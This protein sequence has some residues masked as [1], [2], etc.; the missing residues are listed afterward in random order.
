[1]VFHTRRRPDVIGR[2][3]VLIF[4]RMQSVASAEILSIG[5][6]LLLGDIVDT[7]SAWLA[8]EL[9]ARSIDVYW[10]QRVGDNRLRIR[11]ALEQALGRS[12]LVL[13]SGGLGPTDDDMTRESIADTLGETP[14]IDDTLAAGLRERFASFGRAMPEKNLKQAWRI[15]SAEILPNPLG[16]APGW[17]V[18]ARVGGTTGLI[19]TLPGP[20]RELK[21]MF[22]L[23]V[24][25]RLDLPTSTLHV[26][27]F[28]TFGVGESAVAERLGAWTES[29]NP[30][31]ATYAKADGVWVRVAAKAGSPR[32]ASEI[33][34]SAERHVE[35]VLADHIWGEA[36]DELANLVLTRLRASGDSV[37][38]I[39][40]GSG[41]R[42]AVLLCDASTDD[43][44]FRGGVVACTPQA[45]STV[46]AA[47]AAVPQEFPG[48]EREVAAAAHAVRKQF[49]ATHGVAVGEPR[50]APAGDALEAV[51]AIADEREVVTQSLRL[52]GL[53]TDW[54]RERLCY[55]ALFRLW[56]Q[57]NRTKT[58]AP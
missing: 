30:S 27:T 20:P 5:T 16:T 26:R 28:K 19:A 34:R 21:R 14:T 47:D 8:R 29:G 46:D 44:T 45:Y 36:D 57:L 13:V 24:L 33:A 55:S 18:R 11:A 43:R 37:A 58:R 10:A 48:S 25:P 41:G 4:S 15:P 51:L 52:P 50:P 31:V 17:L 42:L 6:E 35:D 53:G 12:D 38:V 9:A 54:L 49:A 23:E 39:E 1:M 40:H 3:L 22:L 32:E 7:N 2:L 56:S